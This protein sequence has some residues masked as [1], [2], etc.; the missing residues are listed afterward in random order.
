MV[1]TLK[2]MTPSERGLNVDALDRWIGDLLP[3]DG[4]RLTAERLGTTMG[5]SNE[6]YLL[7]RGSQRWVLR[8]PPVVKIDAS[9]SNTVREWR[10]LRAL[11]GTP[12]PHPRPLLLCEDSAV[13]GAPFMVMSHVDGFTPGW[14]L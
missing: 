4:G 11:D 9:A 10:I 5:I 1:L 3:R 6:L 12:V 2:R 14:E 13:I 7:R 8:R